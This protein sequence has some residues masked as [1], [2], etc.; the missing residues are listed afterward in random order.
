MGENDL[1]ILKTEF[2]S[3]KWKYLTKKLAYPY[4][5]FRCLDDYKKPVN[6]FNKEEF[7]SKL[8][9]DYLSDEEIE[10]TKQIIK[11]FKIKMEKN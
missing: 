4:E 5:F 10:R 11:L 6:N 7:F 8:K 2:F 3:D 1:D 9:K